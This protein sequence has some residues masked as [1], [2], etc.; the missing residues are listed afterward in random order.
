ME[1]AD[2]THF[3]VYSAEASFINNSLTVKL[4]Y[5]RKPEPIERRLPENLQFGVRTLE[6]LLRDSYAEIADQNNPI[7]PAAAGSLYLLSDGNFIV[8]RRDKGA[9]THSLYHS[10]YGGYTN[11]LEFVYTE[12]GLMQTA[13]RETAEECLLITRDKTPK[14]IV[15][16]DS[17]DYTLESA[18]RLGLDLDYLTVKVETLDPSDKLEAYYEDG[19]NIFSAKAFLALLW[20]SST[21]LTALQIRKLPLSAE[22]IIPI[23]TEGMVKDGKFVHFNRESYVISKEEISNK[24]FGTILEAPRVFQTSIIDNKPNVYTPSYNPPYLGPDRI[25]VISPHVF[26]PEEMLTACL[27]GLNVE[28]YKGKKLEIELWKEKTKLEGRSLLPEKVLAK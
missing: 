23:D 28:G 20:E 19:E 21:S 13:L 16:E 14:L 4:S 22:D 15:P 27:D 6:R 3:K 10:A 5:P 25:P 2:I 24:P 8:H 17:K 18:K 9:P 12:H 11:S 1:K 26:A 7:K